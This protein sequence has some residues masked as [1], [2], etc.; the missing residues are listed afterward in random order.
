MFDQKNILADKFKNSSWVAHLAYLTDIY[1]SMNIL[2]K[3]FQGKYIN[4]I[5][6]RDILSVFGL[7]LQYWRLKAEQNKIASFSKLAL[8][9]EDCENITFDDI[10]DI[11]LHLHQKVPILK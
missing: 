1:E 8:F 9:L 10:K 7:K 5:S 6:A 2:N 11:K 3:E 4:I